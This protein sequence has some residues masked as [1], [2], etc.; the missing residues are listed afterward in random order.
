[1]QLGG[2]VPHTYGGASKNTW[3]I[4]LNAMGLLVDQ[5]TCAPMLLSVAEGLVC[6]SLLFPGG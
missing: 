3:S 6:L 4:T 1:M 5:P 2:E